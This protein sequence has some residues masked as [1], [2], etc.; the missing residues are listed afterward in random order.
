MGAPTDDRGIGEDA[1]GTPLPWTLGL[2]RPLFA[3]RHAGVVVL[4]VCCYLITD[5]G[6]NHRQVA[7]ATLLVILPWDLLVDFVTRRTGRLPRWMP[8]GDHVL[9]AAFVAAAP[10][11]FVPALLLLLAEIGLTAVAFGRRSAFRTLTV[12]VPLLSAAT[13]I[14]DPAA[15]VVGIVGYAVSATVLLVI[16]GGLFDA[17]RVLRVRH[18][19]LVEDIDAIVWEADVDPCSFTFVSRRATDVLGYPVEAWQDP[20]FWNDHIHPSDR[21]RVLDEERAAV[22]AGRNHT[23]EYRMVAAD[24][25]SVHL[26]DSVTVVTDADGVT[27]SMR[28]VM[29]DITEQREAQAE[30]RRYADIVERIQIALFVLKRRDRGD[31]SVLVV[32]AANPMAGVLAGVR[33]SELVGQPAAG[34]LPQLGFDLAARATEVLDSGFAADIGDI[35]ADAGTPDE[36]H[37][38]MHLFPLDDDAVGVSL[39]D[40]TGPSLAAEALRHQ[41]THDGLTGLPNRVLLNDRLHVALAEAARTDARVALL[42]MDLDQF[43]EINDALGHHHGD[44]LLQSLS[45]R[46]EDVLRDADT[47]ARLGGDEFGILLTTNASRAG[48]VTV[49]RRVASALEQPFEV[50]GLSLQTGASIGIAL[51][52]DHATEA[53]SLAKRADVAMYMAKRSASSYAVYAAEHDRSSVRRITLLGELRRAIEMAELRVHHQPVFDL[54]TRAIVATEAL[55]RWQHPVHG[56][57]PPGEFIDLA[58]VSGVIQQLTR[59]VTEQAVGDAGSWPPVGRPLG[60][61]VNLSVRNL[62]DPDLIRWFQRLLRDTAFAPER[63]TLEIT[64]NEVMDDPML[65]VEVLGQFHDLGVHTSIDDFGT[66]HSS[67]AYLKHLPIDELKIDG[68]FVAGMRS[69][70]SDATIVRSIIE[71]GH[72]LG[73]T[74]VAE[75]V[76]DESTLQL[77]TSF[78]CDRAQGFHLAVPVTSEGLARTLAAL[79]GAPDGVDDDV[80][81]ELTAG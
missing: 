7:L 30:V 21:D 46:L 44:R 58:E 9:G 72:N 25:H 47:I 26:R 15:P 70:D 56:L 33:P 78:G 14:G 3:A 53:E 12:G 16:I 27:T 74:V 13:V 38:S 79:T 76:E 37:F 1:D 36:R 59:W 69:S 48:A 43:K 67:L 24:G 41:A 57:M 55:V 62:Y 60:V 40:V 22:Q 34:V 5:L 6:A 52:P 28:G 73:L 35:V 8:I 71:L 64:E 61:A 29:V 4:A 31:G 65:A 80:R 77:L 2:S 54:Q 51:Y 19:E 39:D 11:T 81:R 23:L 68:S 17:E 18:E 75:G 63:L 42:V 10:G 66:G 50:D 32:A 45:R 20:T 49:A